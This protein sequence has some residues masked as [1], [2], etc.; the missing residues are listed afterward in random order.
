MTRD[1][2]DGPGGYNSTDGRYIEF[3]PPAELPDG[4]LEVEL[5]RDAAMEAARNAAEHAFAR[6]FSLIDGVVGAVT[7]GLNWAGSMVGPLRDPQKQHFTEEILLEARRKRADTIEPRVDALLTALKTPETCFGFARL[8]SDV[9]GYPA[10]QYANAYQTYMQAENRWAIDLI[11]ALPPARLAP[12]LSGLVRPWLFDPHRTWFFEPA[13]QA[14]LEAPYGDLRHLDGDV[15]VGE[16][17]PMELGFDPMRM[18]R[19][20]MSMAEMLKSAEKM[21]SKARKLQTADDTRGQDV[22]DHLGVRVTNAEVDAMGEVGSDLLR[23]AREKKGFG[24]QQAGI[25]LAEGLRRGLTPR[26][27]A[28]PDRIWAAYVCEHGPLIDRALGLSNDTSTRHGF[29]AKH[30]MAMLRRLPRLPQRTKDV[31]FRTALSKKKAGRADAQRLLRGTPGLIGRLAKEGRKKALDTRIQAAA[32]L[33]F[34]G[35]KG[36]V[37]A[38][39]EMM[40]NESTRNGQ[41]AILAA[42]GRLGADTTRYAPDRS[43]LIAE[44][45]AVFDKAYPEKQR[46]LAHVDLPDLRFADGTLAPVTLGPWFLRLA[47][48]LGLPEGGPLLDLRLGELGRDSRKAMGQA[49]LSAFVE[50]DTLRWEDLQSSAER[51]RLIAKMYEEYVELFDWETGWLQKND[52]DRAKRRRE[53][54]DW[55]TYRDQVSEARIQKFLKEKQNW[56]PYLHSANDAKGVLGLARSLA[57]GAAKK[58][59]R[60][61]LGPHARRTAQAKAIMQ[62]YASFGGKPVVSELMRIAGAQKQKGLR[63]H[64]MDLLEDLGAP[65]IPEPDGD[66]P[67]T[68][69][70]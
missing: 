51:P 33:G 26:A 50:Y 52:P 27:N 53:K 58:A 67:P 57:P 45:E 11:N 41:N 68:E 48:E 5:F 12:A 32:C 14:F 7:S 44:A 25:F 61:Y 54:L 31:V 35:D 6:Q 59:L 38:L 46:W 2:Q 37:P 42:L 34:S 36:A 66:G 15:P 3:P 10:T 8:L 9:I 60:G 69:K 21:R 70:E 63:Q 29:E 65:Y 43:A 23:R 20:E 49:A 4:P 62:L 24:W 64:A 16:R 55:S 19:G 56:E 1:A 40:A 22:S 30:A 17:V 28:L 47:A 39:E 13:L 18:M